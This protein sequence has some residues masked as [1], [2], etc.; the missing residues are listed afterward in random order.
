VRRL[1]S[2]RSL[3]LLLALAAMVTL[4]LIVGAS[5]RIA[6]ANATSSIEGVWSFNGGKVAIQPGPEGTFVGTVVVPTR[7]ALCTHP[8]GEKMWTDMRLQPNGSY[9]GLHQWFYETAECVRNP[10][11]GLT[12]WRVM[13]AA[14]GGHYLLVCFSSP[15]KATQPTIGPSGEAA[16]DSYGCV[17]SEV[18]SGHVAPLPEG[19]K[20][21]S[22]TRAAAESFSK[23]VK[24]P[25]NKQCLSRRAFQIHLEDPKY[26][27]I[28]EVVITLGR[29]KLTVKRHGNV[30]AATIN[31]KGLPR[32]TFTVKIRVTTVLGHHL[33][34]SRTYHTCRTRRKSGKP[35]LL[36]PAGR[37]RG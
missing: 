7:F 3:P 12:A 1:S 13:Q 29:R 9:W 16:G 15:E 19:E 22:R 31:L 2:S 6:S 33:T 34:G 24:L 28:K 30:F 4:L 17:G 21:T 25:N 36:E 23:A 26:D 27:P 35:K 8:D 18:E 20:S 37:R 14:N 5:D 11:L 32:G 10:T